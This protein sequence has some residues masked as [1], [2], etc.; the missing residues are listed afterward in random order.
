M[1]SISQSTVVDLFRRS[2]AWWLWTHGPGL[3]EDFE[4]GDILWEVEVLEVER[5]S[6]R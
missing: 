5:P 6:D 4:T 2:A 3:I 1:T